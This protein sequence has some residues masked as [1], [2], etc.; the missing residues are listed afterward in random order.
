MVEDKWSFNGT[1]WEFIH[2]VRHACVV[3]ECVKR[4][5]NII[6]NILTDDEVFEKAADELGITYDTITNEMRR[7]L[8]FAERLD[9]IMEKCKK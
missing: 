7:N 5:R 2:L 4:K 8:D 9:E 3:H 1:P 6:I